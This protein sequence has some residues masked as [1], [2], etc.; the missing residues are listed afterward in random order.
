[1]MYASDPK[2][3]PMKKSGTVIRPE[4][5]IMKKKVGEETALNAEQKS[6]GS[7]AH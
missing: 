2:T 4:S 3:A 7:T 5:W 6:F 1:M